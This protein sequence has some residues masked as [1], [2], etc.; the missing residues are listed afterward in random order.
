MAFFSY[1]A[2]SAEGKLVHGRVQ[3]EHID[4]VAQRLISNGVVPLDIQELG[5]VGG[6]DLEKIGRRIG[7]GRVTTSDLVM[8]SRQMYTI[9]RAGIPLLRGLRGLIASTHNAML[10][11]TLTDV[12]ESL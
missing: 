5:V 4:Q 2:R 10:R 3:G 11:E 9:T 12:L 7:I 6:I 8:F 1:R